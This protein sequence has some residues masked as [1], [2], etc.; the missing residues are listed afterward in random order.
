MAFSWNYFIGAL[1]VGGIVAYWY[2]KERK[3]EDLSF[4]DY[5]K[6][7]V[8]LV[9]RN[10]RTQSDVVKTILVL[11]KSESGDTVSP[12]LYRSYTDGKVKKQK[13]NCKPFPFAKCPSDVRDSILKGEYIVYRF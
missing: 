12:Y 6:K 3:K 1:A 5:C 2:L 9:S 7:C 8:D 13:V 10:I 4:E 11:T